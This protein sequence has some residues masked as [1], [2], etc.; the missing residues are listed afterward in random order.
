MSTAFPLNAAMEPVWDELERKRYS[1]AP[2]SVQ[3]LAE[4][5]GAAARWQSAILRLFSFWFPRSAEGLYTA[6]HRCE[7]GTCSLGI[8]QDYK[9]NHHNRQA[10]HSIVAH[11]S[12]CE[13]D[14]HNW[15][16]VPQ[17]A[18]PLVQQRVPVVPYTQYRQLYCI[19]SAYQF[20]NPSKTPS[21]M[22]C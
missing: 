12:A 16:H 15:L 17:E 13:E 1:E 3:L 19:P 2:L 8:L 18:Q 21:A 6:V 9:G 20:S 11:S 22:R 5:F 10:V 4:P 14:I 7:P